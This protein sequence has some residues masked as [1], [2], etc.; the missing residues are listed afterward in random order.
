MAKCPLIEMCIFFNDEMGNKPDLISKS[1]KI[2]F[3]QCSNEQCA[4]W[5]VYCE[6]GQPGVP[7]ELYPNQAD[8][9]IKIIQKYKEKQQD[10]E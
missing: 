7:R 5:Q 9:V 6:L 2:R 10:T 1:F 4:R 8:R 3:C